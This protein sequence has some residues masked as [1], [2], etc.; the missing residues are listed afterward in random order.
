[1]NDLTNQQFGR[2]TV[3]ERAPSFSQKCRDVY[4]FCV[5]LCGGKKIIVGQSL[6]R[7]DH[8]MWLLRS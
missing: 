6:R 5:C 3:K 2:L 8:I 7:G 4:W 1:M